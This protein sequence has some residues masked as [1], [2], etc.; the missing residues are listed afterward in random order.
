MR[1]I[2]LL[3]P[4]AVAA[5]DLSMK[6]QPRHEALSAPTWWPG[7]ASVSAPPEGTVARDAPLRAAAAANPPA[8]TP[9]LLER[10]RQ[11][12]DVACAM[13]HGPDGRGNGSIVLRG[14]PAPESFQAPR[15]RALDV[16]HIVDVVTNGYGT[17]YGHA[18][19]VEPADRWAIA[20]YVKALGRLPAGA[21][22]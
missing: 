16:R 11:R 8:L 7:G 10:G 12:Y 3:A 5:C 18:D 2:A 17:M 4:L 20:A 13:C 21:A 14:F 22:R 1:A 6:Q 15:Q 9:A 19:R